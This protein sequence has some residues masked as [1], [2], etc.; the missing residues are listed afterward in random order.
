MVSLLLA[1]AL[2]VGAVIWAALLIAAPAG[3]G[4]EGLAGLAG[5]IYAVGSQIC[6]QRPDRSFAVGDLQMP[7]CARCFGL[8][9]SGAIGAVAASFAALRPMAHSRW[10]LGITA[11]P[12]GLTWAMEAAGLAGFS[13]VVRASAAL[14]LG[15]AAG[16]VFVRMLRYDSES[17][18]RENQDSRTP[19]RFG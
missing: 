15:A 6:H 13:N 12:T 9:L 8:Y 19:A 3:L 1:P 10:L 7:V 5:Y 14:P 17:H 16:W 4:D 2:T 11:L 18:A